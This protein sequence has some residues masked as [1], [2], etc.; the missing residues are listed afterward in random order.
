VAF[1][2]SERNGCATSADEE[3]G[4][5]KTALVGTS[6]QGEADTLTVCNNLVTK[7]GKPWGEPVIWK[8]QNS[9][10]DCVSMNTTDERDSLFIQVVRAIVDENWWHLLA[11]S[12]SNTMSGT[13]DEFAN[14]LLCAIRKKADRTPV[15]QRANLVLAIDASR[16]AGLSQDSVITRVREKYGTTLSEMGFRQIWLVGPTISRTHQLT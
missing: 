8:E 1:R 10:I 2:E 11:N 9:D 12:G 5:I 7:L 13:A 6:R 15:Q 16:L 4:E 14:A 3:N